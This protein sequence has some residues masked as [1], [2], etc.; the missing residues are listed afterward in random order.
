M[1]IRQRGLLEQIGCVFEDMSLD[2]RKLV[3]G[4]FRPGPTQTG[5]YNHTR[6][7]EA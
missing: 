7:L 5:L 3:F 2:V 4:G 1:L 6:R